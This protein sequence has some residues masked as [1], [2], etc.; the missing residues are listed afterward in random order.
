M[1]LRRDEEARQCQRSTKVATQFGKRKAYLVLA[2]VHAEQA[3]YDALAMDLQTYLRLAPDGD[4]RED[5]QNLPG[6]R[7]EVGREDRF[8]KLTVS[9]PRVGDAIFQITFCGF[10]N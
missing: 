4:N 7:A 2:D 9:F 8:Y 5:L 1:R 3:H 10:P 6:C